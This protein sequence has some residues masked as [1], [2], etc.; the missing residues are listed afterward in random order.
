ML[1][2]SVCTCLGLLMSASFP[3]Q[4]KLPQREEVISSRPHSGQQSQGEGTAPLISRP[5]SVAP[6]DPPV[7]HVH[8]AERGLE[9]RK[10]SLQVGEVSGS[11]R[12][13]CSAIIQIDVAICRN[14]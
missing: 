3:F 2:K 6:H 13:Q 5:E 14:I 4:L 8:H 1:L 11:R 7:L 12:H 10:S 9:V